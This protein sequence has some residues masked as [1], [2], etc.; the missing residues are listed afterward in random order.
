MSHGHHHHVTPPRSLLRAGA[1]ERLVIA[2]GALGG[3]W[4]AVA[5]AL[6]WFA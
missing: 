5:W 4:L 6:D 2:G 3:L 1:G